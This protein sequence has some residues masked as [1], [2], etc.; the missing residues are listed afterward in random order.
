MDRAPD[1]G[2]QVPYWF[3][4]IIRPW[5][6]L[7]PWQAVRNVTVTV[8]WQEGRYV[9]VTVAWQGGRYVTVTVVR[10]EGR[11]VTATV[12][13]QEGRYVTVTVAWQE[14]RNVSV[15]VAWQEG[16][17]VYY[18]YR[19][20]AGREG[21]AAHPAVGSILRTGLVLQQLPL[22]GSPAYQASRLKIHCHKIWAVVDQWRR[23]T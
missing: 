5:R 6:I 15:T 19:S 12:A 1:C 23:C 2:C 11:Y 18:S 20:L 22:T 13:W 7:L 10:Q 21:Q 4:L 17:K 3:S 16:R 14:G 8:A 9:T